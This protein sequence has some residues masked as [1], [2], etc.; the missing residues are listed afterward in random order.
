MYGYWKGRRGHGGAQ[1]KKDI[2]MEYVYGALDSGTPLREL[3]QRLGMKYHTLYRRHRAYQESLPGGARRKG[4]VK[5]R[6]MGKERVHVP[7]EWVYG[8]LAA[9]RR[10]ADIAAQLHVGARTLY[11]RHEEYRRQH[12]EGGPAGKTLAGCGGRCGRPRK[13]VDM[14][15]IYEC[16]MAGQSI[17]QAAEW[18]GISYPTLKARHREYQE[19][20]R[21]EMGRYMHEKLTDFKKGGGTQK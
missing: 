4:L 17:R 20:H 14:E 21:G 15:C 7:M 8:Q 10:V 2:D 12:P 3:L 16:L 5:Y 18:H 11:S 9:G 6:N 13:E 1:D 19:E